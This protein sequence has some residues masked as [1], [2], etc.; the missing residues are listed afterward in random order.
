MIKEKQKVY[1]SKIIPN[2]YEFIVDPEIA[3]YKFANFNPGS[4]ATTKNTQVSADGKG[5]QIF[6]EGSGILGLI[7]VILAG[8]EEMQK[9]Q[10]VERKGSA[11]NEKGLPSKV[12][13]DEAADPY[14]FFR[15]QTYNTSY[16]V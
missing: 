8:T 14:K 4:I 3:K 1:V 7:N 16:R 11:G 13:P 6:R 15:V 10:K 2:E 5:N 9:L 12:T